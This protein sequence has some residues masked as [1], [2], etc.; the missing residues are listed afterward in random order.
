MKKIRFIVNPISGIG[1]QRVI[2][3]AVAKHLDTQLFEYEITYTKA[4]GHAIELSKEAAEQGL[5][6]VVAV[7]GDGSVQEAGIGL[8]NSSTALGIIPTGS[9]NGLALHLGI[10]TNV[11]RAV[12]LLNSGVPKSIDTGEVNGRPFIGT[13]GVGFDAHIG[14][15]FDLAPRR[16]FLSYAQI[17]FREIFRYQPQEYH[18]ELPNQSIHTKAFVITFANSS[19]FGNNAVIAPKAR[20]D[21]GLLD[22]CIIKPFSLITAAGMVLRLFTKTM[23]RSSYI[24]ILTATSV[25]IKTRIPIVHLDGEP[26]SIDDELSVSINPLSLNVI[27]PNT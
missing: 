10:P 5:D 1:K 2:E 4:P 3:K 24:T 19:Q 7:G 13:A 27:V 14:H 6:M 17:I 20:I 23:D 21:D 18:I 8:L 12:K 9:G 11:A 15:C 16:G 22:I 26:I 25:K